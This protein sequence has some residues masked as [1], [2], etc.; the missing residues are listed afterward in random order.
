MRMAYQITISLN[1]SPHCL[2]VAECLVG[3][4]AWKQ[5]FSEI[6]CIHAAHFLEAIEENSW[7]LCSQVQP[8]G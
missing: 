4:A 2:F 8:F 7:F 3:L 6:Q 1:G 5:I